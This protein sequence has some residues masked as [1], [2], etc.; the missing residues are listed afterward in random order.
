MNDKR[1]QLWNG[2]PWEQPSRPVLT[3]LHIPAP[4]P[5]LRH[6]ERR[7]GRFSFLI[8]VLCVL[9]VLLSLLVGFLI[10]YIR[11]IGA[12]PFSPGGWYG[13]GYDYG[14]WYG[15]YYPGEYEEG[16]L[17]RAKAPAIPSAEAGSGFTLTLAPQDGTTLSYEAIY[18]RCS[19][20]LV[21][22]SARTDLGYQEGT[23]MVLSE[24]GYI[25]TNAH[26][27]AD[28]DEVTVTTTDNRRCEASLVGFAP[29]DDLCVLK[30]DLPGLVPAV[31]GDSEELAIGQEVA[32]IGDALGYRST[33]TDG[34]ISSIDREVELEGIT[35]TLLQTSAAINTGSSGGML[36]DRSGHVIGITTA[37]MVTSDGSSEAVGFAIPS[38]RLK[39][40]AD[41]LIAGEEVVRGA[42]GITVNTLPVDGV[43]LEVLEVLD[44]CDAKAKG[45][46]PGDIILKA[47]GLDLTSTQVLTHLKLTL[48]AGDSITLTVQR[49]EDIFDVP[50]VLT[51]AG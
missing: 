21:S 7:R 48:G 50:V 17:S 38:A 1:P 31:F 40:V 6:R 27:V 10:G 42:L 35:L 11:H 46:C 2:G 37:K 9:C 4:R 45:I 51:A 20:S 32:A 8:P 39:Y 5:V 12:D 33:I 41:R 24:E 14:D 26:I 36:V 16:D 43:G 22:I 13:Y 25:L 49:G 18:A 47:N 30:I 44:G 3:P 34:I 29:M 23:G 28:T 19:P 15:S